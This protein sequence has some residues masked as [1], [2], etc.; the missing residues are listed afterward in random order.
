MATAKKTVHKPTVIAFVLLI[1][2]M[3]EKLVKKALK[4]AELEPA[5]GV[6]F[7][8][9]VE[10]LDT[11]YRKTVPKSELIECHKCHGHSSDKL[12]A[13]PF[14][15][16]TED[17]PT[18]ATVTPINKNTGLAKT[19]TKLAKA[20]A[21]AEFSEKTLDEAN[22]RITQLKQDG[23]ANYWHMGVEI[24]RVFDL[25]LWKARTEPGKSIP[26][27][28]SFNQYVVKELEL[29]AP[30]AYNMMKV[31]KKCT[32][33]QVARLGSSKL[34]F[35]LT[36]PDHLA[37]ERDQVMR[38]IEEGAS[39][40]TVRDK[41]RKIREK[42]GVSRVEHVKQKDSKHKAPKQKSPGRLGKG[43]L[44]AVLVKGIV[45]LPMFVRPTAKLEPGQV[46]EKRAKK[47]GD[48]PFAIET[49]ENGVVRY[50]SV[51]N[52]SGGLK[53]KIET[54]RPA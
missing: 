47:L 53:L 18:A 33:A 38:D 12:E 1:D 34:S 27:Y 16:N 5:D 7:S 25:Q 2:Q 29:S 32:E 9:M 6:E 49:M 19:N 20:G 13:C 8:A 22:A 40:R 37:E 17:A 41:V 26:A 48:R 35:A 24:A 14:C 4:E 30:S 28:K 3:S 50:Y 54:R 52:A 39:Q 10:Q 21:G 36:L 42:H 15:G 43:K 46:P 23:A 51:V 44:T 31:A 11:H 45:A